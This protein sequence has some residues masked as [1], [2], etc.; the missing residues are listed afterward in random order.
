M[1]YK[2]KGGWVNMRGLNRV[3]RSWGKANLPFGVGMALV[4]RYSAFI[5][6]RFL[7]FS[8]GGGNWPSLKYRSGQILY[9]TGTLFG[10]LTVGRP[11]NYLKSVRGGYRFGIVGRGSYPKGTQIKVVALAHD[12][13]LGRVPKRQIIVQPDRKTQQAMMKTVEVGMRKS[14]RLHHMPK[15]R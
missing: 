1:I 3:V 14:L 7:R 8:R 2:V 5:Q 11:G 6:K 12:Q 13:G 9:K 4:K 15:V 10:A